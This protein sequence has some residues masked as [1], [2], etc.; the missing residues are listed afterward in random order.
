[1]HKNSIQI[2]TQPFIVP[3][4]SLAY[5]DADTTALNHLCQSATVAAGR[6]KVR[7]AT[8][9]ASAGLCGRGGE[10][11]SRAPDHTRK[12]FSN[13]HDLPL[14][15]L[16]TVHPAP[17]IPSSASATSPDYSC[18]SVCARTGTTIAAGTGVSIAS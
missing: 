6:S 16:N 17:E 3:S 4:L 14:H 9:T 12:F 13:L 18:K 7:S 11:A 15:G 2:C 1:M 8:S 5:D 10:L